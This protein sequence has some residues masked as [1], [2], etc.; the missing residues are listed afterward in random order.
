LQKPHKTFL[1]AGIVSLFLLFCGSAL[2][3]VETDMTAGKAEVCVAQGKVAGEI[4]GA[5]EGEI[6]WDKALSCDGMP[7]PASLGGARLRFAGLHP[8]GETT[9]AI[10]IALPELLAGEGGLELSSRVTVIEEGGGRFFSNQE[11]NNC[12][13]DLNVLSAA[14]E[15]PEIVSGT[16][17]CIGPLTQING[18]DAVL[19]GDLRFT[20]FIDWA[21]S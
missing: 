16:L 7:R 13:T 4:F 19:L 12:W 10:I 11:K 9:L 1:P 20:G 8:D 6:R 2:S 21:K 14:A 5:I 3:E 15:Q 17:Y 18:D